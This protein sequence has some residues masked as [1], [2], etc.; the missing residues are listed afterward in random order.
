MENAIKNNSGNEIMSFEFKENHEK[1]ECVN[2]NGE[3]LFNP[4]TVGK[5][6]GLS[7]STVKKYLSKIDENDRVDLKSTDGQPLITLKVMEGSPR[8]LLKESGLYLFIFKSRKPEAKKFRR[9]IAREV[10]P[11]IRKTG[12]YNTR[13][14]IY[15]ERVGNLLGAMEGLT[16]MKIEEIA[17]AQQETWNKKLSNLMID[18]SRHG[19]GTM[20]EL[21]DELF[22]VFNSDC[23]FDINELA[24]NKG[25]PRR[26]YIKDCPAIA[27]TLYEF[28]F[29][30][31][32]R[33]GRQVCLRW[34][35][36]Q[37][38]LDKF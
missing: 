2:L 27:K 23:G 11:S 32:K 20:K 7:E 26:T 1:L 21:Y 16:G 19:M 10:L 6:L 37:Q 25:V 8:Y 12:S 24:K 17:I 14:R 28:A 29:N 30:H 18:C 31:F 13:G 35:S 36:S 15:D 3:P 22:C 33:D 34:N 38:T 4:F 9:W 5:C